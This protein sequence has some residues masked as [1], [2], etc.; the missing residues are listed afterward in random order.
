MFSWDDLYTFAWAFF[1][2]LPLV[3]FIHA[4]G[5]VFFIFL[6]G[7]QADLTIGRGKK[8]FTMGRMHFFS[9]YFIDAACQYTDLKRETKWK[10]AL[11]YGGGIIFNGLTIVIINFLIIQGILPENK[12]FYQL[13]YFS[14]YYIFFALLPVDYGKNNP[15]DGKAIY[16]ALRYG[17]SFKEIQ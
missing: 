13:G 1:V 8:I 14:V 2:V 15:S 11:I 3:A 10:H 6:F 5:H 17:Y 9:L 16:L 7:G 12:F 4:F